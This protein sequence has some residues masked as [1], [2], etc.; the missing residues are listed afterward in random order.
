MVPAVGAADPETAVTSALYVEGWFTTT[1][2]GEAMATVLVTVAPVGVTV[3][4]VVPLDAP[5]GLTGT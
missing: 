5:K 1:G 2:F 3:K 4:V